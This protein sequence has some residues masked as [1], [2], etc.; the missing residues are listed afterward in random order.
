MSSYNRVVLMGH[1]TRD[2]EVKFLPSGTTV[3]N[4]SIA[5]NERYTDRDG[6][7][8]EKATFVECEAWNRSAEIIGDYFAKGMPIHLEGRLQLDQWEND[9]GEKRSKLK[10]RVDRFTFVGKKEDNERIREEAGRGGGDSGGGGGNF[11]EGG[12]RPNSD[13]EAAGDDIPF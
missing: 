13:E 3:A 10:V 7:L 1:L 8:Q 6:N 2:P 4:F 12:T 9:E 5:M 11:S